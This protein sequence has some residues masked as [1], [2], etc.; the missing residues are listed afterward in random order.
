MLTVKPL[1]HIF[2]DFPKSTSTHTHVCA[3]ISADMP[4]TYIWVKVFK[5]GPSKICGRQ[6][7]KNLGRSYHFKFFKGCLPQISLGPFLN[8]LTHRARI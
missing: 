8:T 6:P 7:L 3:H 4:T 5:N 2:M 1:E